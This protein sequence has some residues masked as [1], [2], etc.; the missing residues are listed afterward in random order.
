MIIKYPTALYE[1]VLPQKPSDSESVVYTISDTIPPRSTIDCEVISSGISNRPKMPSSVTDAIRRSNLGQLIFI[2]KNNTS[3]STQSGSKLF[4][5]GQVLD[6]STAIGTAIVPTNTD[7][8]TEHDLCSVDGVAIG[9]DNVAMS[10]VSDSALQAQTA[11]I[12]ILGQLQKQYD[13]LES[14]IVTQQGI[15]NEAS[16]VLNGLNVIAAISPDSSTAAIIDQVL[17]TQK[18][19]RDTLAAVTTELNALPAQIQQCKDELAALA[20]LV[21]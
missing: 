15:I 20:I 2:T 19:A 10:N 9:L 5:S 14:Q 17:A 12:I 1:S 3:S 8:E 6:F 18:T 11:V 7:L 4:Y 21:Q 16:R 13:V